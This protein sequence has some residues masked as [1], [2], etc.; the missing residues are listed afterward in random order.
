M[1]QYCNVLQMYSD[2]WFSHAAHSSVR[3][4][5]KTQSSPVYYYYLAYRGSASFSIIFGDPSNDYGVSH[6]DELQYLFPVGEQLFQHIP[7]SEKD[8]EMVD[9]I[10]TL[11]FNFA[12][13]GWAF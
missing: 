6:A 7:L 10:T 3:D 4:Y 9:T 12:D 13:S 1:Q 11:W 2:A 8:Q 5:L